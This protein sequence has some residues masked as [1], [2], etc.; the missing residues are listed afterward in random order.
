M[1]R[2]FVRGMSWPLMSPLSNSNPLLAVGGGGG[3]DHWEHWEE[4]RTAEK[5][6]SF[7]SLLN[8]C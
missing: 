1:K 7:E 2:V 6:G 5:S 4:V 8:F 3:G